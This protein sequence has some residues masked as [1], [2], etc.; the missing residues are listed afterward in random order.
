M[1]VLG[2]AVAVSGAV[3]MERGSVPRASS[4]I[5]VSCDSDVTLSHH[6]PATIVANAVGGLDIR[7]WSPPATYSLLGKPPR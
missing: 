5:T 2:L 4:A 7:E 3:L 1:H 6:D